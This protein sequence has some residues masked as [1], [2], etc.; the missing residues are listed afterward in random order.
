MGREMLAVGCAVPR[1]DARAKVTGE[2]KFALDHYGDNIL[3]GGVKRAGIPHGKIQS[4][5]VSAAAALPGVFAVLTAKDVPGTNRQG[6][7]HKDQPVLC[8]GK[9]RHC[10]DPVALVLA[11]NRETLKEALALIRLG[12]E[13]LPGVFDVEE[14]LKPE[15][16][17][18]HEEGNI[19]LRAVV[20]A[21][22]GKEAFSECAVE[23]EGTFEV[24]PAAHAFLETENGLAYREAEGKVTL[25]VSTQAPFRDRFE[26]AHALGLE[27]AKI[28]VVSPYLGGAFGGKDGATVQCL[29]ALA[30]LHSGGR[31]VKMWWEREESFVAGYKRHAV[32]MRYRLGAKADGTLHAL[33]C[34][35]F[36]DTGAYAHLGGEIGVGERQ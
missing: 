5:D 8:D 18:V 15:A 35:L 19:L 22:K 28:R 32:R 26:I 6:I 11:E 16:P 4:I 1:V 31:P 17:R 23:V 36:Y 13:P 7:V 3:W 2:E 14:A 10:G 9:I 21:G 34:Q 27:P 30:A 24:P 33:H 25:I 12:L 29:L 20:E